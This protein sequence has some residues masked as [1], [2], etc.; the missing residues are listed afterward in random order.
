MKR[1]GVFECG[2][3]NAECGIWN[4]ECGIWNAECGMRNLEFGIWNA[5][6]K[7]SEMCSIF[8]VRKFFVHQTAITTCKKSQIPNPKSQ[9]Q[10]PKS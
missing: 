9:I 5:E 7:K 1:C 8:F 6:F 3:W 4:A 10:H 2:I